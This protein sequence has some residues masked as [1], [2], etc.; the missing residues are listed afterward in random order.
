MMMDGVLMMAKKNDVH[1]I[2]KGER[3]LFNPKGGTEMT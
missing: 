2:T 3:Y 1:L